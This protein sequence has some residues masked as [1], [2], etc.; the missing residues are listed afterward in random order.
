[1]MKLRTIPRNH[2]VVL[3][4][5]SA[6]VVQQDEFLIDLFDTVSYATLQELCKPRS[7][8]NRLEDLTYGLSRKSRRE[9]T[10]VEINAIANTVGMHACASYY[11]AF[12]FV[13]CADEIGGIEVD[14]RARLA[15]L[16]DI[17]WEAH[18]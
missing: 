14:W 7:P 8:M 3:T 16:N 18:K 1:M 9:G 15:A 4:P 12:V 2:L 17:A 11:D 13:E 10:L 5:R 6:K